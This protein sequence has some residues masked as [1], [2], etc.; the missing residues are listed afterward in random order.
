MD[1]DKL[2]KELR[3]L[4][5][6][7][8]IRTANPTL[9]SKATSEI[10]C[11]VTMDKLVLPIEFYYNEK[12][13]ITNKHHACAY[14]SVHVLP[15]ESVNEALL[16]PDNN[17]IE[18]TYSKPFT[19]KSAIHNPELYPQYDFSFV[20]LRKTY[21][22]YELSKINNQIVCKYKRSSDIYTSEIMIDRMKFAY[23]W[24]KATQ[25]KRSRTT[26]DTS[27]ITDND[28]S[29]AFNNGASDT[30]NVIMNN[31]QK[32]ITETGN[33][34]TLEVFDCIEK[35]PTNYKYANSIAEYLFSNRGCIE[36]MYNWVNLATPESLK[37][38]SSFQTLDEA[39]NF[40]TG[41]VLIKK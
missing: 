28:Y 10:F 20:G 31:I 19:I 11:S 13:G 7:V 1:F 32:Q 16:M 22:N 33:I 18:D 35:M 8:E 36:I 29:Y 6:G 27:I 41:N 9:Y 21:D 25:Y 40:Q 30:Y 23:I 26:T 3:K 37:R 15:L 38:T 2:I 12:N 4:N 5:P 17:A 39:R 34:D 24:M 14:L